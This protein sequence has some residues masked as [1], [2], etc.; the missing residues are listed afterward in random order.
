MYDRVCNDVT[1]APWTLP[2]EQAFLCAYAN[3]K[4]LYLEIDLQRTVSANDTLTTL[5]TTNPPGSPGE[6][7]A[8]MA[9]TFMTTLSQTH[10]KL[11]A[12]QAVITFVTARSDVLAAFNSY[13]TSN[14]IF[15]PADFCPFTTK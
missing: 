2:N 13:G 4:R 5:T 12:C 15:A 11:K 7:F 1:L 14:R 6:P 3:L 10:N 9:T 8:T